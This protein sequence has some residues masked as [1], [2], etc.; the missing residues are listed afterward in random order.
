MMDD[1]KISDNFQ[2]T[3]G[4]IQKGM[5]LLY[6]K[7]VANEWESYLTRAEAQRR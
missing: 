5:I 6:M 7:S 3:E 2:R 4:F 1:H